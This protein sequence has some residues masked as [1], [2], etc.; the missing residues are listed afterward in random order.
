[1]HNDSFV[2]WFTENHG[3]KKKREK[4]LRHVPKNRG[5]F[6]GVPFTVVSP[7]YDRAAQG[8]DNFN[9]FFSPLLKN[10]ALTVQSKRYSG[11]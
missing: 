3:N 11:T 4:L 10:F 1:M 5:Y 8:R 2:W 9:G 7:L 6:P